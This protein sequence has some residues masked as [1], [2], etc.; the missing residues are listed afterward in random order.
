M[1][2]WIPES[3]DITVAE[4]LPSYRRRSVKENEPYSQISVVRYYN[5]PQ[6]TFKEQVKEKYDL[7]GVASPIGGHTDQ[8]MSRLNT[9]TRTI[10]HSD[11]VV[12]HDVQR[13]AELLTLQHI[14]GNY[15]DLHVQVFDQNNGHVKR[16]AV[17]ATHI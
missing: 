6:V 8:G 1:S 3:P 10:N 5:H 13:Q 17:F 14:R 2:S 7:I 15:A 4:Y 9:T 11:V 16:V 12:L